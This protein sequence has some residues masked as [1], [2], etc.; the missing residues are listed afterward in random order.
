MP[1]TPCLRATH[2]QTGMSL[3]S[4]SRWKPRFPIALALV[5]LLAAVLLPSAPAL[6]I[7]RARDGW[8]WKISPEMP[9]GKGIVFLLDT[10]NRLTPYDLNSGRV[11]WKP[12]KMGLGL[13]GHRFL[14]NPVPVLNV[15]GKRLTFLLDEQGFLHARDIETGFDEWRTHKA[16]FL[17]P[18][19]LA[20]EWVILV[21]EDHKLHKLEAAT[22]QGVRARD[23]ESK[24]IRLGKNV[25]ARPTIIYDADALTRPSYVVCLTENEDGGG[26]ELVF[27]DFSKNRQDPDMSL[28]I[29]EPDL[30]ESFVSAPLFST[31]TYNSRGVST[32]RVFVAVT[33][34]RNQV[35][36]Q[37]DFKTRASPFAL[38]YKLLGGEVCEEPTFTQDGSMILPNTSG[39][40]YVLG[41]DGNEMKSVPCSDKT[42]AMSV[43]LLQDEAA[44]Y[45]VT[46]IQSADSFTSFLLDVKNR[47]GRFDRFYPYKV[48]AWPVAAAR[49]DAQWK[50]AASKFIGPAAL[51]LHAIDDKLVFTSRL[52]DDDAAFLTVYRRS[53]FLQRDRKQPP[54]AIYTKS[55]HPVGAEAL[56]FAIVDNGRRLLVGYGGQG[57][58]LINAQRPAVL[59]HNP[60]K[61]RLAMGTPAGLLV[62]AKNQK[63]G[64]FLAALSPDLSKTTFK[65]INLDNYVSSLPVVHENRIYFTTGRQLYACDLRPGAELDVGDARAASPLLYHR[66]AL[67]LS[68][69]SY[70]EC[71]DARTLKKKWSFRVEGQVKAAPALV[72]D[73][74]FFG[75]TAGVLYG[76]S[77]ENPGGRVTRSEDEAFMAFSLPKKGAVTVPPLHHAKSLYVASS[78]P[79]GESTLWRINIANRRKPH[80]VWHNK[81]DGHINQPMIIYKKMLLFAASERLV[82][83]EH[84]RARAQRL[85]QEMLNYPLACPMQ[86]SG[87]YLYFLCRDGSIWC[88]DLEKEIY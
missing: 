66:G 53:D 38:F 87:R 46:L 51:P 18:P 15:Q 44:K 82:A 35:I 39:A 14:F 26:R 56:S 12:F 81:V 68:T 34:G 63:D 23:P 48:I 54:K 17:Y 47:L 25:I 72:G 40:L 36:Y 32:M 61:T 86:I 62:S 9:R 55:S 5:A 83:V 84:G 28:M 29:K 78:P 65:Q 31:G 52:E 21:A 16:K 3:R 4:G 64:I 73:D 88:L 67:V 60:L 85:W 45:G 43:K 37:K 69:G 22:G 19:V 49:A 80:A 30:K 10:R 75:T 59:H 33:K 24:I 71:F 57:T 70:V 42:G 8:P 79:S 41:K 13:E 6:D 76:L 7:T 20:G 74:L 77:F 11:I 50:D 2:R 58:Y 1:P 27:V